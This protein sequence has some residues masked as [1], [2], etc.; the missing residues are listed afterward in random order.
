MAYADYNDL[1]SLTEDLLSKMVLELMGSYEV[2]FHSKEDGTERV[3]NF[4]PPF[5]R[6]PMMDTLAEKLGEPMPKDLE[7]EK[8]REF[9]D[10]QCVKHHIKCN[11]PR[12]IARL[13]D[14]L[15]GKFI[16]EE[17]LD[18]TFIIEHP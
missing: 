4:K 14:K 11:T 5:K 18:P 6:V 13:I 8:A 1:M 9:F 3:I 17:C 16:E 2:H 15:V 12:T 7:S 10:K